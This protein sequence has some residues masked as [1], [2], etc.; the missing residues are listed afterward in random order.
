MNQITKFSPEKIVCYSPYRCSL[1]ELWQSPMAIVYSAMS[2]ILTSLITS[3]CSRPCEPIIYL[4]KLSIFLPFLNHWTLLMSLL[5]RQ[6]KNAILVA[7]VVT[8]I[9]SFSKTRFISVKNKTKSL[10]IFCMISLYERKRNFIVEMHL[11]PQN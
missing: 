6:R 3:V 9:N 1:A 11:K 10:Y 8:S 4:F 5:S 2:A 7:F